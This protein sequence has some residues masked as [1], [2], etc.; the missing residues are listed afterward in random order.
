[1]VATNSYFATKPVK[2]AKASQKKDMQKRYL[3]KWDSIAVCFSLDFAKF[4]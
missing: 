1:M 4:L 3:L 2:L